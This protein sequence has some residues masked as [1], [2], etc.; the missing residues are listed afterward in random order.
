VRQG[1]GEAGQPADGAAE[2]ELEDG[3]NLLLERLQLD[4]DVTI[5][6]LTVD[7]EW[8]CWTLEDPVRPNGVKIW[9]ETAIPAGQYVVDITYSTRFKRDLPLLMD[10]KGFEG[11]RIHVG[12][13]HEDTHGCIL[14]GMDRLTKSI[15]HSRMAFDRL[16]FK[17]QQ[18]KRAGQKIAMEIR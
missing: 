4:P 14:V 9:G 1:A 11:I 5:G 6:G 2:E 17:L 3:M 16:F 13:T 7:G 18:A 10:V 12:N 15:G 8:E